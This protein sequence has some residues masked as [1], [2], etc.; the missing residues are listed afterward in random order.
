VVFR[1]TLLDPGSR[2]RVGVASNR[3]D[4]NFDAVVCTRTFT[5]SGKGQLVASGAA[6]TREA[7][8]GGSGQFATASGELRI[9]PGDPDNQYV[10]RLG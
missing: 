3:C 1:E 4:Y 2:A 6:P 8:L 10:F 5:L 7:V 9:T